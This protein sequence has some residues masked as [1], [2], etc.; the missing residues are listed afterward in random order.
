MKKVIEPTHFKVRERHLQKAKHHRRLTSCSTFCFKSTT[1]PSC[2]IVMT[3]KYQIAAL[4][5]TVSVNHRSFA[6][7]SYFVVSV[8]GFCGEAIPFHWRLD[9]N[10]AHCPSIVIKMVSA[11]FQSNLLMTYK[12]ASHEFYADLSSAGEHQTNPAS[13]RGVSLRPFSECQHMNLLY[14][15]SKEHLLVLSTHTLIMVLK[16]GFALQQQTKTQWRDWTT[17][18]SWNCFVHAPTHH[19]QEL[20]LSGV[21]QPKARRPQVIWLFNTHIGGVKN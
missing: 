7:V 18:P 6:R 12:S 1:K 9:G 8:A 4:P 21:A 3:C 15:V 20:N 10:Y 2:A 19:N 17:I 5:K 13:W 16:H 14:K 11:R